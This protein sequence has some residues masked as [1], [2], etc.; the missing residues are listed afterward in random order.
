MYTAAPCLCTRRCRYFTEGSIACLIG[1]ITAVSLL[2]FRKYLVIGVISAL[3]QFDSAN[4]F[5]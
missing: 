1:L 5:M 4:F 3:L 2:I